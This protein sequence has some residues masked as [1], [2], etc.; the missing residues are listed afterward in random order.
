MKDEVY[1]KIFESLKSIGKMNVDYA[2]NFTEL[3][4]TH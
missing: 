2:V 3:Y 4:A 1:N